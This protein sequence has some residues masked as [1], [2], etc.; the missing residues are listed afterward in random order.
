MSVEQRVQSHFD[1]DARRFDQIY[2]DRKGPVSR[3]LDEVWRGVVRKRFELT[4]ERL[5]PLEGKSILDV[6]CGPGRYCVAFAA[7]G[8]SR[9]VGVDIAPGM[10]ELAERHARSAGVSEV[11]EFRHGHFPEAVS[12]ESFDCCT[13]M[14][15]FDYVPDPAVHLERMRE[16]TTGTIVASFP[17]SK[18]FRTLVRRARFALDRCPLFLYNR[19]Q[20][21]SLLAAA[22]IERYELVDLDR[23]LILVARA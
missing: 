23:D 2:E 20:I 16:L 12:G 22:G 1:A 13:A 15:Y 11:C 6:G 10:L 7:E 17:K 18:G 8:A 3:F 9:V 4:M 5:A 14:G 19:G 21:E